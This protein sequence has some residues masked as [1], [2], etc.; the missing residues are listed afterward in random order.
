MCSAV[1]G[2]PVKVVSLFLESSTC[3]RY[4]S[5]HVSVLHGAKKNEVVS[6][7]LVGVTFTVGL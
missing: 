7:V 4:C 2:V 3:G 1:H 6:K 5:P